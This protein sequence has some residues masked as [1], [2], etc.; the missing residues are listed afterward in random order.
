MLQRRFSIAPKGERMRLTVTHPVADLHAAVTINRPD[1]IETLALLP[2]GDRI[3]E[4]EKAPAEPHEFTAQLHL[5]TGGQPNVLQFQME[6]P[7]GHH[8]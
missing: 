6:E 7:E 8:H 2:A 4:S 1:Q 3:F 5:T